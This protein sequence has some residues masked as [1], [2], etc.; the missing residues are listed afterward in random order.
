[1]R[2]TLKSKLLIGAF[3]SLIASSFAIG[4][5]GTF[6]W[7]DAR[8]KVD[9]ENNINGQTEGSYFARGNGTAN[10][11]FIIN[12]PRHLYN[13]AWLNYQGYFEKDEDGDGVL[14]QTFYFAIDPSLE[15]GVLD[16]LENGNPTVIPPIGTK[17]HPFYGN[18]NGNGKTIQNFTFSNT[19]SEYQKTPAIV[20]SNNFVA[21]QIVG[22][23]GVIGNIQD[24]DPSTP[25]YTYDSYAAKFYNT[26]LKNITINTATSTSLVGIAAGYVNGEL[27]NIKTD[28]SNIAVSNSTTT[29]TSYTSNLSDYGVVGFAT[30]NYKNSVKKTS[31]KAYQV[32]TNNET[33]VADTSGRTDA[34]GG[35]IDM[36]SMHAR[37][38]DIRSNYATSR[39]VYTNYTTYYD[40]NGEIKPGSTTRTNT[41]TAMRTYTPTYAGQVAYDQTLGSYAFVYDADSA[42][43]QTFLYMGAGHT[44]TKHFDTYREHTGIKLTDGTNYLTVTAYTSNTGGTLG[45]L[46]TTGEA[47]ATVWNYSG[48]NT[49]TLSTTFYYNNGAAD[50]YY[51]GTAITY[52]LRNNNGNL[53]LSTTSTTWTRTIGSNGKVRYANN[54]KYIAFSNGSWTLANLPTEPTFTDPEPVH[55]NPSDYPTD[56][57][58]LYYENNGT[59][60]YLVPN[61]NK[62]GLTTSTSLTE[63]G[64]WILTTSTNHQGSIKLT[65]GKQIYMSGGWSSSLNFGSAS[66]DEADSYNVSIASNGTLTFSRSMR[67]WLSTSEYYLYYSSGF[68]LTDTAGNR[69]VKAKLTS[70]IISEANKKHDDWQEDYDDWEEEHET[71]EQTMNSMHYM[72]NT[73]STK[74]IGPDYYDNSNLQVSED[75]YFTKYNGNDIYDT[76]YFPLN[77]YSAA[78]V[79]KDPSL[80]LYAPT[81]NNTGYYVGGGAGGNMRFGRHS[82]SSVLSSNSYTGG[83]FVAVKT[84]NQNGDVT[85]DGN[86]ANDPSSESFEKYEKTIAKLEGVMSGQT[87]VYGM[88]FR[89]AV[90]RTRQKAVAQWA[91]I[92]NVEKTNYELVANSIDFNLKEPGIVNFVA[93]TYGKLQDSSRTSDAD[94]FFSL[95]MVQRDGD[96]FITN[97]KEIAEIYTDGKRGHAYVYKFTDGTY[98]IP[99]AYNPTNKT[100]KFELDEDGETSDI[101]LREGGEYVTTNSLPAT[102]NPAG[103]N[104]D[105]ELKFKTE[106]LKKTGY[107]GSGSS[108]KSAYYTINYAYYFEI[109]INEGE[110]ALGSVEGGNFGA[111][112]MY[113]DIGASAL[114]LTRTSIWEHQQQSVWS[115][116]YP[117]GVAVMDLSDA[118]AF[119]QLDTVLLVVEAGYHGTLSLDRNASGN[120]ATI[121]GTNNKA[122]LLF[123]NERILNVSKTSAEGGGGITPL[124][125]AVVTD[126]YRLRYLDLNENTG[127]I[128]E[129]L[130]TDVFVDGALQGSRTVTQ[131]VVG[132]EEIDPEDIEVYNSIEN[133]ATVD[134]Q[135]NPGT[136]EAGA[137]LNEI[138]INS[139]NLERASTTDIIVSFRF[140][141]KDGAN[142]SIAYNIAYINLTEDADFE[143]EVAGYNIVISKDGG[144]IKVYVTALDLDNV[145][146]GAIDYVVTINGTTISGTSETV[147][148]V[149]IPSGQVPAPTPE[150]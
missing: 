102:Y 82:A 29:A 136:V 21:P 98:S 120:A 9:L 57:Y 39:N 97:V 110:Y 118:S 74:L 99:Y 50:P 104:P 47:E 11:P 14:D 93:G 26:N 58:Q 143:D 129:T 44:A 15:G 64:G 79:A 134:E 138:Q 19:Y 72:I 3:A 95:H 121:G 8:S 71:W 116:S 77:T 126:T 89:D 119:N 43:E 54:G 1:M 17:D 145:Y 24:S 108:S 55:Y 124:Y 105:A 65:D 127:E 109:P 35:S 80:T 34:W 23:I 7:F 139:I 20:T 96:D 49:G 147:P 12:K 88:H 13:L 53:Q 40:V 90:I 2:K 133:G 37:L 78:D 128:K 28:E 100:Q 142:Y 30:N 101:P 135:G 16:G 6:A 76:S 146:E 42:A 85:I 63:F 117:Y 32:T 45:N 141:T 107:T 73:T 86:G 33:F 69:N 148:A 92:N 70:E 144:E 84:Y 140:T 125:D 149:T 61:A 25:S 114:S 22:F 41:T 48:G 67:V 130:I 106:W 137:R 27:S 94:S 103:T 75:E 52:Y 150:P 115:A 91:S 123:S 66:G 60:T 4:L 113:L 131:S 132:G 5:A 87:Y 59:I 10:N 83:K 62:N 38:N 81:E 36:K 31:S 56:G 51:G 68:K 122:G 46:T 18:F 112:L 111:Y